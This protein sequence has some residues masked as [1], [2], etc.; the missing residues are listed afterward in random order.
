MYT[1]SVSAVQA[2]F[3]GDKYVRL[4]VL[5][6]RL[7]DA[8]GSTDSRFIADMYDLRKK[9][10]IIAESAVISGSMR[11]FTIAP[12]RERV[13][14]G[15]PDNLI[16]EEWPALPDTDKKRKPKNKPEGPV[17][18]DKQPG[19]QYLPYIMFGHVDPV[20]ADVDSE[21]S[22]WHGMAEVVE[23]A[24]KAAGIEH[25]GVRASRAGVAIRFAPAAE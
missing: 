2:A 13:A 21:P 14:Y 16:P 17:A 24:L 15:L 7:R 22:V 6:T 9:L 19:K 8:S 20:R 12:H 18:P 11:P 5:T 23:A 4:D 10:E 25:N 3:Q 1:F